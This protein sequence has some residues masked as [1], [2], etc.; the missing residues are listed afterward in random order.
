L[1]ITSTLRTQATKAAKREYSDPADEIIAGPS[2]VHRVPLM[3]RG[4]MMRR[5]KLVPTPSYVEE[6]VITQRP[7]QVLANQR[8]WLGRKLIALSADT[9]VYIS[10]F[11]EFR[12]RDTESGVEED[13]YRQSGLCRLLGNPVAFAVVELL[14]DNKGLNPSE[15]ARAVGRS[16]QR[17][18]TVLGA[19]PGRDR[20][21]RD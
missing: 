8:R 6:P 13:R 10:T 14:A 5:S 4:R 17:V 12:K 11:P 21:L 9:D 3:T 15:I 19:A 18:S 7:G 1:R 20:A 2:L 16:A